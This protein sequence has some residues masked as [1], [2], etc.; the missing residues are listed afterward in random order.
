MDPLSDL[1]SLLKPHAFMSAALEAGGDWALRFADQQGTIKCGVVVCGHCRLRVDGVDDTI[2]LVAGDCFVLPHGRPFALAGGARVPERDAGELLPA[3]RDGGFVRIQG[4]GD[5]RLLSSRFRLEGRQ[6]QALLQLLP[7]VVHVAAEATQS[8]LQATVERMM[9]ELRQRQA[10]SRIVLQNLALLV[11]VEAMRR[12]PGGQ[13]RARGGW[14]VALGDRRIGPVLEA[15]H[16]DP[17]RGW[18]LQALAERAHLARSSFVSTFKGLVGMSPMSYVTRWRMALAAEL[19]GGGATVARA[20][21]SVGYESESAFST[22]FKRTMGCSPRDY[23]KA[24]GP[25]RSSV[26]REIVG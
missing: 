18:T 7:A 9:H 17:A 3:A 26:A 10:G 19:L 6:P 5:L 13:A 12:H 4:G 11:L 8:T 21:A 25:G 15:F 1:L 24:D 16:A 14:L 22:A 20:A 2:A 23:A